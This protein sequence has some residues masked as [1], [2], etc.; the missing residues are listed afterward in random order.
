MAKGPLVVET[1]LLCRFRLVLMLSFVY[2][3]PPKTL[4]FHQY[5]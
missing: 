5:E 3:T 1:L 4:R 2:W